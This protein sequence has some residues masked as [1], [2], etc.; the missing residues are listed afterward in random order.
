LKEE[1]QI[2]VLLGLLVVRKEPLLQFGGLVEVIR[3]VLLLRI[4]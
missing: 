3:N 2:A 4:G 1:Q